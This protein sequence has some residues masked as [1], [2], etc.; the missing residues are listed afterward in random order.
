L[1]SSAVSSG[2]PETFGLS[3]AGYPPN[4]GP[5]IGVGAEILGDGILASFPFDDTARGEAC[6]R[7]LDAAAEVM[8]GLDR[9]NAA[10]QRPASRRLL[11]SKRLRPSRR[12]VLVTVEI[13]IPAAVQS[14]ANSCA[15]V[16]EQ[17]VRFARAKIGLANLSCNFTR[18][19]WFTGRTAPT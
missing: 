15:H 8:A 6:R 14:R 4:T 16:C 5:W 19:A 13:G 10:R 2:F 11:A 17:F 3:P 9:L 12:R 18:L 7:A 1:S